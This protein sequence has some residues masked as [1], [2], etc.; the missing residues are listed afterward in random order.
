MPF[1][2]GK[3]TRT[4]PLPG[5]ALNHPAPTTGN[6]ALVNGKIKLKRGVH[7]SRW[8]RK[9]RESKT[10]RGLP[11]PKMDPGAKKI[12]STEDH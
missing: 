10:K 4:F 3:K 2:S 7:L 6:I 9:D 11:E 5:H 8:E 12:P 1:K